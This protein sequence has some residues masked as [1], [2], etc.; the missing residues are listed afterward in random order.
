[1]FSSILKEILYK[2]NLKLIIELAKTLLLLT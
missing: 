2:H 1:M